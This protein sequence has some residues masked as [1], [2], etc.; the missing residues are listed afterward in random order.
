EG[1]IDV[2]AELARAGLRVGKALGPDV[3]YALKPGYSAHV[4]VRDHDPALV[5]R[6]LRTLQDTEWCGPVLARAADPA[7]LGALPLAVA[8]VDSDRAGDV[9]FTLRA[10]DRAS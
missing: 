9:L 1:Q 5:D 7:S 6:L 8:N 10:H 4:A 2:M 3:D